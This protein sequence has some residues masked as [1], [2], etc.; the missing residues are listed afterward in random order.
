MD[1]IDFNSD[2]Q[3]FNG[4]EDATIEIVD[5]DTEIKK[6]NEQDKINKGE[7][8]D[9]VKKQ[10]MRVDEIKVKDEFPN[11]IGKLKKKKKYIHTTCQRQNGKV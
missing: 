5:G 1:F 11:K 7:K 10:N 8:N 9:E 4:D 3:I 2:K 6:E